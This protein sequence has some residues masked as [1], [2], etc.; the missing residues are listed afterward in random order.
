MT[1]SHH[2]D[3]KPALPPRIS[4]PMIKHAAVS[5]W[6]IFLTFFESGSLAVVA[7]EEAMMMLFAVERCFRC[8]RAVE[9]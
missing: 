5:I 1:A 2:V 8:R 6:S 7:T 9:A 4:S 3:F